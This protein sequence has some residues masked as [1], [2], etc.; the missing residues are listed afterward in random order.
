[1]ETGVGD[2]TLKMTV[3]HYLQTHDTH[4]AVLEKSA[5]P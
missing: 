2:L 5:P 1:M 3:I 4:R